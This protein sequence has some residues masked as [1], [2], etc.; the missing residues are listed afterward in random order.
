MSDLFFMASLFF[1]LI[2]LVR[3]RKSF[4]VKSLAASLRCQD[5]SSGSGRGRKP[6]EGCCLN[7]TNINEIQARKLK[8]GTDI[9]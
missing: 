9:H 7:I 5:S 8:I 4:N 6:T 1:L 3:L 2:D